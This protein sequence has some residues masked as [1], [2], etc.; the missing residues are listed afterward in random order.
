MY[1]SFRGLVK[2]T[3]VLP[4]LTCKFSVI[5]NPTDTNCNTVRAAERRLLQIMSKVL[6][7]A[8]I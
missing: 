6:I 3:D 7:T 4:L 2:D 1:S 8:S 5:V